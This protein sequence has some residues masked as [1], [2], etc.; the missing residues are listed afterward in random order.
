MHSH[1][2][3]QPQPTL[4]PWLRVCVLHDHLNATCDPVDRTTQPGLAGSIAQSEHDIWIWGWLRTT[5]GHSQVAHVVTET[6]HIYCITHCYLEMAD[7]KVWTVSI[8]CPRTPQ[9]S[10]C[11]MY[12][13][14]ALAGLNTSTRKITEDAVS[15]S[16]VRIYP[17]KMRQCYRLSCKNAKSVACSSNTQLK[18]P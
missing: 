15:R 18:V 11:S 8:W 6:W 4:Y 14:S 7:L 1:S 17:W 9:L 10:T 3:Y 16:S 12:C 5:C 13:E 2:S